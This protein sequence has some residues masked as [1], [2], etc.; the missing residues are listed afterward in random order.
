[1]CECLPLSLSLPVSHCRHSRVDFRELVR[2]LFSLFKTRIW[3]QKLDIHG[4][5]I[6]SS[7]PSGDTNGLPALPQLQHLFSRYGR[8]DL[9]TL[10]YPAHLEAHYPSRDLTYS[11]ERVESSETEEDLFCPPRK[12]SNSDLAAEAKPF[13]PLAY[14]SSSPL[15]GGDRDLLLNQS[16]PNSTLEPRLSRRVSPKAV[17]SQHLFF[18]GEIDM[19]Y[20]QNKSISPAS[21]ELHLS[22]PPATSTAYNPR[23]DLHS[24]PQSKPM[25]RVSHM[26]HP[27]AT[28]PVPS[29]PVPHQTYHHHPEY[30]S[31]YYPPALASYSA[32]PSDL[33]A[34]PFSR[35]TDSNLSDSLYHRPPSSF[36]DQEMTPT[37][38]FVFDE[39]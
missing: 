34:S 15:L 31:I 8:H 36:D 12:W 10:S 32:R 1:M 38:T 11:L 2:D 9:V 17:T 37:G 18:S 29:R 19:A 33:N 7:M 26:S 3:M 21:R 39:F 25:P 16:P 20:G 4:K 24:A 6:H 23:Y 30:G 5:P 13:V 22:L 27:Y 28:A 35:S 14:Q